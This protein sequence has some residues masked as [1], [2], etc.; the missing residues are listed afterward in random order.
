LLLPRDNNEVAFVRRRECVM[1]DTVRIKCHH[2]NSALNEEY[3]REMILRFGCFHVYN[4]S[5]S[6]YDSFNVKYT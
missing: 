3:G 1:S 6:S 4:P 2:K 5:F